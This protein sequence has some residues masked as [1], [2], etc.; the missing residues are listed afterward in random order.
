MGTLKEMARGILEEADAVFNDSHPQ[1]SP[2][3]GVV[4]II[5]EIPAGRNAL[6]QVAWRKTHTGGDELTIRALTRSPRGSYFPAG[7][8]RLNAHVAIVPSLAAA[9]AIALGQIEAGLH[10]LRVRPESV[11]ESSGQRED[12]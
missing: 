6:L 4:R 1:R 2:A 10:G 3:D 5:A 8:F 12:R 11:S 7:N 9:L